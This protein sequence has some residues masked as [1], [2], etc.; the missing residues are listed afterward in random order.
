MR[1]LQAL[2]H[3]GAHVVE[4]DLLRNVLRLDFVVLHGHD[5]ESLALVLPA[6]AL[7]PALQRRVLDAAEQLLKQVLANCL[8]CGAHHMRDELA[9]GIVEAGDVAEHVAVH[10]GPLPEEGEVRPLQYVGEVDDCLHILVLHLLG[11]QQALG[12]HEI[13]VRQAGQ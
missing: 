7:D 6:I 12:H 9:N 13:R 10:L 11:Q 5:D 4:L 2:G 1:F 3:Q 8:E